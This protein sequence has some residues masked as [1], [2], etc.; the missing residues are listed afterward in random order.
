MNMKQE[1][2]ER[3]RQAKIDDLER[4]LQLTV[5]ACQGIEIVYAEY[6]FLADANDPGFDL[7]LEAVRKARAAI[8]LVGLT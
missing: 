1:V 5:E 6:M 7:V 2:W 3:L 8:K 4:Q